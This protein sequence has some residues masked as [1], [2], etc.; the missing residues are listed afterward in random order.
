MW[1]LMW[2]LSFL[3]VWLRR[4]SQP[5]AYGP[6][7]VFAPG[8]AG[9]PKLSKTGQGWPVFETRRG[10]EAQGTVQSLC[11]WTAQ[12]SGRRFFGYFLGAVAKK[13]TRHQGGTALAISATIPRAQARAQGF[14]SAGSSSSKDEIETGF[15][16]ARE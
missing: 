15:P 2:L 10:R 12:T 9:M 5:A 6:A 11:D 13:V 8:E 7:R 4:A 1:L 16:P 3:P 14:H